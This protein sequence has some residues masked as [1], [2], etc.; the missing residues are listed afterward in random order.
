MAM[1]KPRCELKN[2]KTFRGHDG[3]GLDADLWI[4]GI[5]CMHIFDDAR[6][7]EFE[8]EHCIYKN[9][10]AEKVKANIR[11]LEDW[12]NAQPKVHSDEL[13][14]DYTYDLDIFVNELLEEMEHKKFEA[15]KKKLYETAIVAGKPNSKSYM[16]WKLPRPVAFYP[17]NVL[18]NF[19]EKNVRPYL[20][21]GVVIL[22]PNLKTLGF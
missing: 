12:I 2:V 13:N 16:S 10:K 21:D 17:A 8:Y 6:G 5:K 1:T 19:I 15:K 22:N 4:N 18:K 14:F 3:I 7:G 20:K 11:L 9:P